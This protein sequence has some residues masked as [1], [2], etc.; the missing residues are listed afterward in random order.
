MFRFEKGGY[1]LGYKD[2][3]FVLHLVG[4]ERADYQYEFKDI[5]RYNVLGFNQVLVS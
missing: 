2:D 1:V 5:P 3:Y 4:R